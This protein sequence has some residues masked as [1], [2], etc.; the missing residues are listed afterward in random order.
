MSSIYAFHS[1]VPKNRSRGECVTSN[2]PGTGDRLV[3]SIDVL[4]QDR[5]SQKFVSVDN[6]ATRAQLIIYHRH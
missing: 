6:K 4:S 3:N 2:D 1:A 5:D